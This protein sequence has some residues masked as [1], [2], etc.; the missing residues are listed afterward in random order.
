MKVALIGE[1]ADGGGL[2]WRCADGEEAPSVGD[3]HTYKELVW[4]DAELGA[5]GAKE[6]KL[7][8]V[9]CGGEPV[10]ADGVEEAVAQVRNG[11]RAGG[12]TGCSRSAV[13]HQDKVVEQCQQRA[14]TFQ[15][16]QAGLG[17]PVEMSG[18]NSLA[19]RIDFSGEPCQS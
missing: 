3:P 5:K 9:D 11:A 14:F 7:L 15:L 13:A 19:S 18:S 8:A 17:G 2:T 6:S 12:V 1:P 10:E 4:G 16:G